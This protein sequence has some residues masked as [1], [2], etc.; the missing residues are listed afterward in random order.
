VV[1]RRGGF[2]GFVAFVGFVRRGLVWLGG[3]GLLV[4]PFCGVLL[5]CSF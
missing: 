4:P 5:D 2:G 1:G 3:F